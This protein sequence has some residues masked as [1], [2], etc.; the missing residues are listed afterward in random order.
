VQVKALLADANWPLRPLQSLQD[1]VE[2]EKG[3]A[4]L[5]LWVCP[6]ARSL[7]DPAAWKRLGALRLPLLPVVDARIPFLNQA[8]NLPGP[9]A[10]LRAEGTGPPD[11]WR[12]L[13]SRP[14]RVVAA[15]PGYP[16]SSDSRPAGIPRPGGTIELFGD[17]SD[18][19]DVYADRA[20]AL[21]ALRLA[22]SDAGA[23]DPA[24][25]AARLAAHWAF[26]EGNFGLARLLLGTA[27]PG[28]LDPGARGRR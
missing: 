23:G 25:E 15:V 12:A 20:D 5:L 17:V 7:S 13:A 6:S 8:R 14:P 2:A 10:Y 1:E 11:I 18:V 9:F 24:R 21:V 16:G 28:V 27:P 4:G 26:R 19:L 3:K 22:S